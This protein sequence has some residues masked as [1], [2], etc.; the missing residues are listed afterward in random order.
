AVARPAVPR[1]ARLTRDPSSLVQQEA[2]RALFELIDR[3][4]ATQ[5][6]AM[7]IAVLEETLHHRSPDLR[8]QAAL[9]LTLLGRVERVR[10]VL[11]EAMS[12]PDP[13]RRYMAA[14]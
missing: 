4:V 11:T 13:D 9:H 8:D 3:E 12:D 1:I 14:L 5:D 7:V 2:F 10:P 6:D